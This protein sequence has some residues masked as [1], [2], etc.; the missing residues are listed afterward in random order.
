MEGGKPM[1]YHYIST[2]TNAAMDK[3]GQIRRTSKWLRSR[4]KMPLQVV[5]L[6]AAVIF[7]RD[8]RHFDASK[9]DLTGPDP[10]S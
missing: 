10:S 7:L 5:R 6:P 3:I 1:E 2:F 4:N 8:L 9:A